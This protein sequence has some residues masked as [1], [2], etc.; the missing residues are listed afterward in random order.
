ML[1]KI[2]FFIVALA[3]P[4]FAGE[5]AVLSSGFRI[6]AETHTVD[7]GIV[8]L[9][10]GSGEITLPTSAVVRFEAE[11]YAPPAPK[12]AEIVAVPAVTAQPADPRE[13]V[14]LAAREA[15]LPPELVDS[16]VRAES[17]Y[18]VNTVSRKGAVG[19]MQ[20]MP[21]TAK[22]L[23]AD[24]SDPAQN[25]YAGTMYLRELLKRYQNSDHQVSQAL[26]AYNAG[27]GAVDKYHGVPPYRETREYVNRVLNRYNKAIRKDANIQASARP[28]G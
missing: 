14:K 26:A 6:R 21:G 4:L 19:L 23:H 20:L 12:S 24:A 27:P 25:I 5:Y 18:R 2:F 11:E 8:H 1:T 3:S 7:G 9:N 16:V 22:A 17:G 15:E 28:G 10:T 13:I